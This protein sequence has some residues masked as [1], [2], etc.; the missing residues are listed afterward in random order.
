MNSEIPLTSE[1]KFFLNYGLSLENVNKNIESDV[2]FKS[3]FLNKFLM[4]SPVFFFYIRN[5]D[6][7]IK[8][9]SRGKSGKYKLI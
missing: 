5:V 9:Y 3:I 1:Y 2:D 6:K 8:K 7:K 4:L